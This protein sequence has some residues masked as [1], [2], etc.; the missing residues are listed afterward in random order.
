MDVKNDWCAP[1]FPEGDYWNEE[2]VSFQAYAFRNLPED[3][4]YELLTKLDNLMKEHS[5]YLAS[6]YDRN[7][8]FF[9]YEDMTFLIYANLT[10]R[11][12]VFWRNFDSCSGP[13]IL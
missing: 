8:I 7:N 4:A 10:K 11:I 13:P 1:G 12:R 2:G 6:D 5:I 9:N 3:K